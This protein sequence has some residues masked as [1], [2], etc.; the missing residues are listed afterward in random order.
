MNDLAA[1]LSKWLCHDLATPAATVM[2]ASELLGPVADAEINE[3]VQDGARRLVGRLRLLRA[4]FGPGGAPMGGKALEKLVR[5]GLDGTPV[6][7]QHP[8]DASGDMVALVSGAALLL[9]DLARGHALVVTANGVRWTAPRTLPEPVVSALAGAVPVDGRAA[10][11]GMVA[12]AAA[13]GG[14]A[15]TATADGIGWG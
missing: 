4:A 15:L 9:G 14:V 13:R 11:A 5:D 1:L 12:A 8:A 6:D 2:T 7:W 10:V 3:L